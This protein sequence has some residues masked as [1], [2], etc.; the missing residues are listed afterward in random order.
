MIT[1]IFVEGN[2]L[3]LT[4]DISSLLTFAIDDVK[5]FASRSTV[6]SKTIVLPGTFN[7][8]RIFGNIFETGI[9]NDYDPL[10]PNIGTNF[11]AGKSARCY[12]FQDNIQTFKGTIRMTQINNYRNGLD[13]EMALN[14]ELT[15]LSVALSSGFLT[16]LDFSAYDLLYNETNVSA[17]WNNTPGSGVYFPLIDYG[18]YSIDKH[19]WDIKTFRPAL[20]VKEYIDKMFTAASF[21]YTCDLFNTDRFKRLIIPHNQKTLL[22]KSSQIIAA[23]KTT[24]QNI[25]V[26]QTGNTFDPIMWDTHIAGGFTYTAGEFTYN[27]ATSLNINLNWFIQG[28]RTSATPG[29]FTAQVRKKTGAGPFV[30]LASAT[31]TAPP[32]ITVNWN[33]TGSTTTTLITNDVLDIFVKYDGVGTLMVVTVQAG[34]NFMVSSTVPTLLPVDYGQTI[35]INDSI[36]QNIRQVDFLLSIVQLFNLYVYE[37]QFDERL[38][39]MSPFVD[40]YSSDSG[41]AIDWTYKLNRDQAI[42]IKPLSEL[43]SKIYNFNYKD[44]TDFWNDLYK[45]RYNQ[46]YGTHIFDSQFEFA[47][48]TNKLELIFA[49]TPLVGYDGEDKVYPTIFKR[50]GN[51]PTFTEENIDSV[52]RIMQTKKISGTTAWRIKNGATILSAYNTYGYAGHF[53]DPDNPDNDLNFGLLQ[54]LFFVLV[55]GDLTKTQFNIYWSSYMAEITDKD[56]KMLIAKFYLTAKDIFNLDFSK[57]IVVDGVLFRLNKITDYNT[58]VPSDCVVELLKVINTAYSFP[59]VVGP[60]S[61]ETFYWIDSDLAFVIDSDNSKI[62]YQ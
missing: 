44:D 34:S 52:I 60:P 35:T 16:D 47:S 17:S 62:P 5:N 61:D 57:Y 1:E 10:L 56:S 3:D 18:N 24:T 13:Y 11:N 39:L 55:T 29:T 45:K 26:T 23:T 21:R 9:S 59:P 54:E 37:S 28:T 14:G 49:S 30:V 22:S 15:S 43:N 6:F 33:W 41:N 50:T 38:I 19:D 2:R 36:P 53:D 42:K 40:F 31:F 51:A 58:T 27:G 7:N 4:A 46:T 8:N 20:Y 25:I 48:Q 32:T 12:L